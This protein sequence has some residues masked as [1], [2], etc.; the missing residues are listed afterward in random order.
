MENFKIPDYEDFPT[1]FLSKI[2]TLNRDSLADLTI[3]IK[4]FT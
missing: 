3:N 4:V 2:K 1:F